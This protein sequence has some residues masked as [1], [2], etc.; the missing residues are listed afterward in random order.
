MS[1]AEGQRYH[2]GAH[3]R[4]TGAVVAVLASL[5]ADRAA[6]ADAKEASLH[7]HVIGGV[8]RLGE[9][10]AATPATVALVGVGARF[11]YA[12][13]HHLAWE[14]AMAVET[15][16]AA[17]YADHPNPAGTGF[18]GTLSRTTRL[19]RLELG[20]TARLG[21]RYIPTI[22]L[23]VGV[24]TRFRGAASFRFQGTTDDD[25]FPAEL[26]LD[27]VAVAGV[28]FDYRISRRWIAGVSAEGRHAVPLGGPSFDSVEGFVHVAAYWYPRW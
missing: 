4:A 28:G 12:F 25:A 11:T 22:H 26:A 20:A 19:A 16:T 23:G 8:A 27:L 15:A 14:A 6:Y 18:R 17:S 9:D 2:R 10:D 5:V 24:A 21:V 7:A 3:L 1:I 13:S